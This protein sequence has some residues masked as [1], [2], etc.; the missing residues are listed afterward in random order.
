MGKNNKERNSATALLT[1]IM[2]Y[3]VSH[4]N[5]TQGRIYREISFISAKC[6]SLLRTI[7]ETG[8]F[9]KDPVI[10][11]AKQYHAEL[12]QL[13][14]GIANDAKIYRDELDK[15]NRDFITSSWMKPNCKFND[16]DINLYGISVYQSYETWMDRF[17]MNVLVPMGRLTDLLQ[18]IYQERGK[19]HE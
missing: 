8:E 11:E 2:G 18:K 4:Y 17:Q 14:I 6:A 1:P 16:M 3:D 5:P 7:K 9:L 19:V 15:I 13:A 12:T 10:L